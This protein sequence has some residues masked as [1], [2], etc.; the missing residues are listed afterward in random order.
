MQDIASSMVSN[1][2]AINVSKEFGLYLHE[3][4][5]MHDE[6]KVGQLATGATGALTHSSGKVEVNP[7]PK[8]VELMKKAAQCMKQRRKKGVID[9]L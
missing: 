8:G 5:D 6:D 9:V 2:T 3:G 1:C 7:F 4:C